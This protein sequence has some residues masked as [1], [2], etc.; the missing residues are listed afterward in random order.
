ML[1]HAL[2]GCSF[3]TCG[4][5]GINIVRI[6]VFVGLWSGYLFE[7]STRCR[8]EYPPKRILP[9]RRLLPGT[10]SSFY[11]T[12]LREQGSLVCSTYS[13]ANE[14]TNGHRRGQGPGKDGLQLWKWSTEA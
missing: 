8:R 6:Y 10:G 7:G 5:T 12:S 11:L 2:V 13:S 1:V 14:L 9:Y 4:I 3:F